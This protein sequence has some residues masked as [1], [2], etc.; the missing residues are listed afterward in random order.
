MPKTGMYGGLA[1]KDS[2][3]SILLSHDLQ[4]SVLPKASAYVKMQGGRCSTELSLQ[5]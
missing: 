5:G 3:V 1:W 2:F 4:G